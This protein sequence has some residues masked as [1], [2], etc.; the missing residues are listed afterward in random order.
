MKTRIKHAGREWLAARRRTRPAPG[1]TLLELMVALA[2]GTI[3]VTTA[4]AL[5]AASSEQF[6]AQQRV[7]NVQT[8]LRNAM[9]QIKR[10]L[11]RAS[12]H[13]TARSNLAGET[14]FTTTT[15]TDADLS[16]VR[17][18][19]LLDTSN[20]AG[21]LALVNMV[22]GDFPTGTLQADRLVM[23]GNY[24]SRDEY[25]VAGLLASGQSAVLEGGNQPFRRSF[26]DWGETSP[27]VL[28]NQVSD[29]FRANRL[30]RLQNNEGY[31][32]FVEIT[33]TNV[34][35]TTGIVRIDF[36]NDTLPL[37]SP[38]VGGMMTGAKAAPL[39]VIRYRLAAASGNT[40]TRSTA[41]AGPN[42]QLVREALN[43]TDQT[44]GVGTASAVLDYVVSFD[45]DFVIDNRD[46]STPGAP[47][48]LVSL[49]DAA[50]ATA[51]NANPE[52]VRAVVVTLSARTP[53]MDPRFPWPASGDGTNG[54]GEI[55]RY[56]HTNTGGRLGASRVRTLRAEIPVS[57]IACEG[58]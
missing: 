4:Y 2:V 9:T 44:Q 40:A 10:D 28:P 39:S 14:C 3:A 33:G 49:D 29:M 55:V 37:G 23:I 51:V 53:E 5:G 36:G 41:I 15:M 38:C 7:S 57:S 27:Q 35:T 24:A 46:R 30:M 8:S 48:L 52:Y 54:A 25:I 22:P 45:V 6:R 21:D 43:P 18:I 16:P 58:F 11:E 19:Q 13:A 26:T 50:A 42:R 34:N 20:N 56:R 32:F 17:P 31:K 1:F 12:Y 47:P